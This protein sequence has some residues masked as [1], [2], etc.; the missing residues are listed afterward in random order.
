[1]NCVELG[2]KCRFKI[3]TGGKTCFGGIYATKYVT[4]ALIYFFYICD[5]YSYFIQILESKIDVITFPPKLHVNGLKTGAKHA[6][7][8]IFAPSYAMNGV[9]S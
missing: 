6:N 3:K 7:H 4:S 9:I 8:G 5:K 1:M 2:T